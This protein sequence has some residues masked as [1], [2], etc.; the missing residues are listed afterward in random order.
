M[1][2]GQ[3]QLP[4]SDGGS[5]PNRLCFK[6]ELTCYQTLYVQNRCLAATGANAARG[7]PKTGMS[8]CLL[9]EGPQ[10]FGIN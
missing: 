10:R 8:S 3:T 7:L 1:W 2:R 5:S 9:D 6:L 4:S